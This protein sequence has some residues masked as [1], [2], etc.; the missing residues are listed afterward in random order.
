MTFILILLLV[1]A[2]DAYGSV[3]WDEASADDKWESHINEAGGQEKP[4]APIAGMV[5][6]G[7]Y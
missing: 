2:W 1:A 6:S 3:Q 4:A 7:K 5:G